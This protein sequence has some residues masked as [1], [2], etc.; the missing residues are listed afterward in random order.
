MRRIAPIV[1]SL[2]V[3]LMLVG[4]AGAPSAATRSCGTVAAPGFH[5][6]YVETRGVTCRKARRILKRWLVNGAKPS[7]G[8]SGWRCRKS[9]V[10]PWRC[11]RDGAVMTFIFHSY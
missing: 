3:L 4:L 1:V 10:Q 6:F 2:A 5:A 7:G 11:R 9:T 8:P